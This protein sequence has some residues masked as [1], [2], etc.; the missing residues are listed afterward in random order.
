MQNKKQVMPA[1]YFAK[2]RLKV[3]HRAVR[4]NG[5]FLFLFCGFISNSIEYH[6]QHT[7]NY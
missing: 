2:E 4:K 5:I 7:I 1:F 6:I 3:V